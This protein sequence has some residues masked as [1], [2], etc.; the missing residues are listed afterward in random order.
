MMWSTA[1]SGIMFALAAIALMFSP[2]WQVEYVAKHGGRH[3]WVGVIINAIFMMG[4]QITG[5]IVGGIA[6]YILRGA[7]DMRYLIERGYYDRK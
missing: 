6:F 7:R 3:A 2:P 1:A 5:M 4:P